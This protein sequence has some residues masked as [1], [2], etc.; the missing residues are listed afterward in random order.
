M[1]LQ[2]ISEGRL[3][4]GVHNAWHQGLSVGPAFL[5]AE[6]LGQTKHFSGTP[7]KENGFLATFRY[8]ID[9]DQAFLDDALN[10]AEYIPIYSLVNSLSE[11]GTVSRVQITINGSSDYTFRGVFPLNQTYERNLDYKGE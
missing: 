9:F 6:Y 4:H 2:K 1:L 8:I 5:A 11:L 3:V 7:Q 10:V